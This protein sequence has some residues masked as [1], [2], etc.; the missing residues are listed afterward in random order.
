MA[1]PTGRPIGF[2]LQRQGALWL[3]ALCLLAASCLGVDLP[4]H[5]LAAPA[6]SLGARLQQSMIGAPADVRT[7]S[8]FLAFR[9][10]FE[11]R[12]A[13]RG[14]VLH[15]FADARY[16]LW[17][18]GR[19]VL[20][21][22]ARFETGGPEYDS[23][24]V[25]RD[26]RS[27]DNCIVVLV[28]ANNGT[29]MSGRMRRHAPCLTASL[30]A[31]GHPALVTDPAWKWSDR[32][33]YR[34]PTIDWANITDHFDS[35]VEDGDWTQ[36]GYD[37]R[38]WRK[39]VHVDGSQWGPLTSRR[40]PL[41]RD[42]PVPIAFEGGVKLPATLS[43]GDRL[44]FTLSRFSQVYTV[45]D[46]TA[47]DGRDAAFDLDYA[48]ASLGRNGGH[49][50]AFAGVS[51][52][53][54]PGRQ[55]FVTSDSRGLA[56]GS[57]LVSSGRVTLHS[58]RLIERLY[59]F[60]LVGSFR[61]SDERLNRL[62][63]V[64][65]RSCQVLSDD[66]YV[67]CADRERVEWMDN[68]PPAFEVTRT[69]L[70]GPNG[71]G[72]L[73]FSDPR[74]LG[75][76][77]RRIGLTLQPEGWVKAHTCSD[78]FD[79]HAK[80]ED[81]ACD[82]VEGARRYLDSSGDTALIREIWPS[83]VRQMDY[84]LARRTPRGLVLGREWVVWGNPA[85]Y[86][87][88]EGAGLNAFIYRA[89]LDASHLGRAIGDSANARRLEQ[90]A[91]DLSAAYNRVLWDES[92]GNYASAWFPEE[93]RTLPE[94][95][96]EVKL[97]RAGDRLEPTMFSALWALDQCIVPEQRRAR[98]RAYLL[99]HRDQ[100]ERVMT[101]YYLFRQLYAADTA[102]SDRE[103]L[104]T[105]RA[106]WA[107]MIDSPW[108]TSWEEFSGG[109]KAHVYGMFPGYFLS[110][111]VLGVRP[112]MPATT[113]RILIEPRLGDLVSAAGTVV[114]ELGPVPVSWQVGPD[115][116]SFSLEVP[117]GA[118]ATLRLPKPAEDC[119]LKLDGHPCEAQPEG[120]YLTLVVSAGAHQGL[121]ARRP[122]RR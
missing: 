56:G 80:M 45:I 114:T 71:D 77:I 85:G 62:W 91:L 119:L 49:D 118:T 36:P 24:D 93:V 4:G 84:F 108:Q 47:E 67:D 12:A 18:N 117:A 120:R 83:V 104:A 74:L 78:R 34:T 11:L 95:H 9:R 7:E 1:P 101:F 59:P 53:A 5:V 82:W 50:G 79:I 17:I 81:R 105:M 122:G 37:D 76:L 97:A 3:L 33:R 102:E 96:R 29:A 99:N 20:E 100:A 48:D 32:T 87:T 88:C 66:A 52:R 6:D 14:A 51:C 115:R 8:T 26:L 90:A 63:A 94:N 19:Y 43:A 92:A 28:L 55:V 44:H 42:T 72:R 106:K 16:L 113:K 70:A 54:R 121:L 22:P 10:S 27:G 30:Y 15:L 103:V 69:A 109:S 73:C 75:A 31:D 13:P 60:V 21:G 46:F 61:S 110:A 116:L 89:L 65:A 68:D 38:N 86:L 35:R 40:T 98:V 111:Y 58:L 39:P 41:L 23:I 25:G 107:G 2:H 64:C 112:E 57:I